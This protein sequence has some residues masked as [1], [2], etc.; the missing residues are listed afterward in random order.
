MVCRSCGVA[1]HQPW[2]GFLGTCPQCEGIPAPALITVPDG[3]SDIP[4]WIVVKSFSADATECPS[5]FRFVLTA[6]Q[7]RAL[8]IKVGLAFLLD[9]QVAQA[10]VVTGL[11]CQPDKFM[12][13]VEAVPAEW[14]PVP[15][16]EAR[17][18]RAI[19]V[20]GSLRREGK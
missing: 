2:V 15:V 7:A 4:E 13:N 10:C 3:R 8:N 6:I 9:A 20:T 19:S 12:I 11:V 16:P 14:A 5:R 18:R 1:Y 17:R